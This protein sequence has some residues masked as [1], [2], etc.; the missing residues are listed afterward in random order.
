M[1]DNTPDNWSFCKFFKG[2][3]T[4][5]NY[6]KAIVLGV[7]FLVVWYVGSL[8]Y[9]NVRGRFVKPEQKIENNSGTITTNN[10]DKRGNSLSLLSIF[11]GK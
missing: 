11:N 4:A 7:C 10:V 3:V 5:K 1:T 6:G 8:I 2:F 9:F